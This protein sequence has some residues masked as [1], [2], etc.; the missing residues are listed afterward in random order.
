MGWKVCDEGLEL[1][2]LLLSAQRFVPPA[3]GLIASAP[4]SLGRLPIAAVRGGDRFA[5]PLGRGEAFWIGLLGSGEAR[6]TL[7][8]GGG[9]E[10]LLAPGERSGPLRIVPGLAEGDAFR[11]LDLGSAAALRICSQG[12]TADID[13]VRRSAFRRLTGRAPPVPIDPAAG[14]SGRRLP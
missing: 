2:G 3:N 11:A 13:L 4:T 7:I 9:T 10:I 14:Y 6:L 5:L 1:G 8:T 12:Q